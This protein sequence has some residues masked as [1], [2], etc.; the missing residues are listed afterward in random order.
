MKNYFL[1]YT[2]LRFTRFLIE[3]SVLMAVTIAVLGASFST[4]RMWL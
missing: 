4:M 3:T 2:H 1:E